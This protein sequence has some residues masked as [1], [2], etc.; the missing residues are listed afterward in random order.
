M[1]KSLTEDKKKSLRKIFDVDIKK[2]NG[3]AS[4]ELIDNTNFIRMDNGKLAILYKDK[5]IGEFDNKENRID[6]FKKKK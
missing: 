5:K 1:K 6:Y 2:E 4:R 3:V